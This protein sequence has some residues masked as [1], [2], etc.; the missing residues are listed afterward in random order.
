LHKC[1][2]NLQIKH[3]L[4]YNL[5]ILFFIQCVSMVFVA[6]GLN[7]QTASIGLRE[8]VAMH[9]PAQL[10][11]L[12][13]LMQSPNISEA[14]VLSTCNRTEIYCETSHPELVAQWLIPTHQSTCDTLRSSLYL[15]QGLD[16]LQH[17][18]RV[19]SGL[20]SMILGEPQILG[21]LKQAYQQGCAIQSVKKELRILFEYAFR[22]SKKI[23]HVS[24][25]GN[26]PVSVASA[27]VQM[28]SRL[29]TDYASLKVFLI[30]SGETARLAAK[31][32]H[33]QGVRKFY[34][35]SRT[36]EHAQT[37]AQEF[38]AKALTI[39]DISSHLPQA[40]VVISA[41]TCPLPFITKNMVER[42]LYQRQNKPMCLLDLAVPRDIETEVN[43]LSFVTLYN[44]DDLQNLTETSL[45]QRRT[46]ACDAEKLVEEAVAHFSGQHR[47]LQANSAICH[48]RHQM[49]Q[50]AEQELERALGK[51]A[52]GLNQEKVLRELCNRLVNKLTHQP[53]V[54]LKQAAWDGKIDLST[55]TDYLL[56]NEADTLTV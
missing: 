36:F 54:G 48:Y 29:F 41:T 50:L 14:V 21:Q 4:V 45:Q 31:Y 56:T 10:S 52:A 19:A 6:C 23:R 17:L 53:T 11:L 25:I 24:Q 27:G 51:L 43:K 33:K 2:T 13:R 47:S 55:L 8:Q 5:G 22:T 12:H 1:E 18:M 40:D 46:S 49:Q 3:N 44:L 16:A 28:I 26:H 39:K 30:G 38:S 35:A 32:L 42:A 9:A 37:L 34:V 15:Y 7:H 20:D